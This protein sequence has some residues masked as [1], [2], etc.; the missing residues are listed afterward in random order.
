MPRRDVV[1]LR[2]LLQYANAWGAG[3][4]KIAVPERAV[5]DHGD[6]VRFAPRQHGVL[7]RAL[8]QMVEYLI[9]RDVALTSD[10]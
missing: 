2:D 4:G 6:I 10:H 1:C 7:D 3:T 5:A 9:A 8:L